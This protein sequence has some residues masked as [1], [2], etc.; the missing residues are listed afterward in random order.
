M[1]II[2]QHL[3]KDLSNIVK[4]LLPPEHDT[5]IKKFYVKSGFAGAQQVYKLIKKAGHAYDRK[6]KEGI[7]KA[8][9][10]KF[11]K[12][13]SLTQINK[14]NRRFGSFIPSHPLQQFQID[15]IF[16]KDH[17]LNQASYGF[18]A[19]DAFSKYAWVELMKKKDIPNVVKAFKKILAKMGVPETTYSDD[20]SEFISKAF[21]DVCAQNNIELIYTPTHATMVERFNQT[22]KTKLEKFKQ[23]SG[24]KTIINILPKVLDSYNNDLEHTTIKMTPADATK[25]QNQNIVTRNIEQSKHRKQTS[26]GGW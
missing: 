8:D 23:A 11:I 14:K 7:T 25:K 9:I 4:G 17:Q 1:N 21:K 13:Q 19:V 26:S 6:T 22:L 15:L 16:I 18:V 2:D 20:G 10:D 12:K 3:P 24:S 5:I